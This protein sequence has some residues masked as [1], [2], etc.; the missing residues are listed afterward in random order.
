MFTTVKIKTEEMK[1][2]NEIVAGE[3]ATVTK[4]TDKGDHYEVEVALADKKEAKAFE[5]SVEKYA[6]K[7]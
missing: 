4:A 2:F 7:K 1:K 6:P 5:K 3:G